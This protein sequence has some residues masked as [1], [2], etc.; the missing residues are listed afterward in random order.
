MKRSDI[1]AGM[2][3]YFNN[4]KVLMT[5]AK[6]VGGP[7]DGMIIVTNTNNY[8]TTILYGLLDEDLNSLHPDKIDLK[9]ER[10]LSEDDKVLW[11]RPIELTIKQIAEKF[12]V[13]P[14]LIRI[15]E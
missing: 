2:K 13:K 8:A 14:E 11:E 15:K 4:N 5:V 12:G 3:L 1:K 6:W 9:L 10:I 7:L